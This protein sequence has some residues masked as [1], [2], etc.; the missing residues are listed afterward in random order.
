MSSYGSPSQHQHPYQQ[1]QKAPLRQYSHQ[2][3]QQQQYQHVPVSGPRTKCD[4][5]IF[6]AMCKACEAIVGARSSSNANSNSSSNNSRFN[7][8]IPPVA[9][10]RSILGQNRLQL[11]VAPLRMDVY[12]QHT[13]PTTGD[14]AADQQQ[15]P[16][17]ELLER[18]CFDYSPSPPETFLQAEGLVTS[19]PMAQLTHVC[20]R[21]VVWL[22]VLYCRAR[23]LP[24]QT[25]S[26][27]SIGFSVYVHTDMN[28]DDV[29]ELL[30]Q[31]NSSGF[32]LLQPQGATVTTPYGTLHW[33]VA[34]ATHVPVLERAHRT[35]RM[36]APSQPIPVVASRGRTPDTVVPAAAH[37]APVLQQQ[38]QQR[39]LSFAE[40][41]RQQHLQQQ[42]QQ[43]ASTSSAAGAY[44]KTLDPSQLFLRSNSK[45][46]PPTP[47]TRRN[48][49]A[50][51]DAI[52]AMPSGSP[53]SKQQQSSPRIPGQQQPERVLSAL[54]LALLQA[55]TEDGE[56]KSPPRTTGNMLMMSSDEEGVLVEQEPFRRAALHEVPAHW[57]GE[58][59]YGVA[60]NHSIPWQKLTPSPSSVAPK[61]QQQ[62][63][64]MAGTPPTAA[65]LGTSPG[66]TLGSALGKNNN[67]AT[68]TPPFVRPVGFLS[69]AS[70][71]TTASTTRS[72]PS[73][74]TTTTPTLDS[75]RHSPFELQ[76]TMEDQPEESSAPTLATSILSHHHHHHHPDTTKA[77]TSSS[78]VVP[79]LPF[80]IAADPA[81]GGGGLASLHASAALSSSRLLAASTTTTTVDDLQQQLQ[82]FQA[83]GASLLVESSSQ[84]SVDRGAAAAASS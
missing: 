8:Q 44:G 15:Q 62:P 12:Y 79:E 20:K 5:V 59:E 67:A 2:Q 52:P 55:G 81:G 37:S 22:R 9:A 46:H 78:M 35:M 76:Y 71:H 19:D 45:H 56:A 25:S 36:A 21:I 77:T 51:A 66:S 84:S 63:Q 16:Q 3:P 50:E 18:W 72:K 64:T 40:R 70:V 49:I 74:P 23:L 6:E 1:R 53:S 30:G 42:Q 17:R 69:D 82:E 10:I 73:A 24:A 68:M 32:R 58:S 47:L 28:T 48:T 54:S 11:R 4:Q 75:L 38:Q 39:P 60:Y 61:Q 31:N 29:G 65:F 57:R 7:L 13:T 80:A 33:K 83:F 34:Y 14:A 43:Q 27:S 41:S 26:T